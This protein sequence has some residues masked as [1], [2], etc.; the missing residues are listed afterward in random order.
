MVHCDTPSG[1][2]NNVEVICKVLKSEGIMTVVDSVAAVG[3][4]QLEVDEWGIDIALGGSQSFFCSFWN[5]NY[6]SKQ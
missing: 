4:V 5:Y 1:V 2:L 3:G 6:D